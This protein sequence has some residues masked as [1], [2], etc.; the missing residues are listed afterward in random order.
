MKGNKMTEKEVDPIYCLLYMYYE[1]FSQIKK[2][3]E[4]TLEANKHFIYR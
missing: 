2:N 1:G 3:T 4:G